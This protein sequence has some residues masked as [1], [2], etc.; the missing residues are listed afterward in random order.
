MARSQ[1]SRVAAQ[2]DRPGQAA[3]ST[4]SSRRRTAQLPQRAASSCGLCVCGVGGLLKSYLLLF[5]PRTMSQATRP[6]RSPPRQAGVTRTGRWAPSESRHSA[7]QGR[8]AVCLG[9]DSE[10]TPTQRPVT[11]L[12]RRQRTTH[13]NPGPVAPLPHDPAHCPP[14]R[15]PA[16]PLPACSLSVLCLPEAVRAGQAGR[17][18]EWRRE[19]VCVSV[20]YRTVQPF[21]AAAQHTGRPRPRWDSDGPVTVTAS[22]P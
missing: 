18:D 21:A 14:T 15:L 5:Y 6:A 16:C 4:T 1:R 9:E 2:P 19:R 20:H 12:V 22:V 3:G 17:R 10:S 13:G 7:R 8:P 11:L